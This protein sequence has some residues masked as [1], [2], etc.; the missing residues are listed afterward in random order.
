MEEIQ[1]DIFELERRISSTVGT[2]DQQHEKERLK[3]SQMH[4]ARISALLSMYPSL[5]V[6]DPSI[7]KPKNS[8]T[9]ANE[10]PVYHDVREND[11]D[12]DDD[13]DMPIYYRMDGL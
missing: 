9:K 13:G 10:V 8:K 4:Y 3:L 5:H 12:D 2:L 7:P 1:E 6:F 11:Y